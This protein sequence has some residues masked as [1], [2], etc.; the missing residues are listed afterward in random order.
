MPRSFNCIVLYREGVPASKII[1]LSSKDAKIY[2]MF[3]ESENI[4]IYFLTSNRKIYRRT[5]LQMIEVFSELKLEPRCISPAHVP[6]L[7]IEDVF[8]PRQRR[9]LSDIDLRNIKSKSEYM[10]IPNI[11]NYKESILSH[12]HHSL[13]CD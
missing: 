1:S 7:M 3:K 12:I 13:R 9:I 4:N 11:K 6:F 10:K 2:N 8:T 5:E